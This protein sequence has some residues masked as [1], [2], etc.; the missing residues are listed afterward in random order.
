LEATLGIVSFIGFNSLV[1]RACFV[2][3]ITAI[4]RAHA[5]FRQ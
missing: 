5:A 3:R 4:V 2:G 1:C